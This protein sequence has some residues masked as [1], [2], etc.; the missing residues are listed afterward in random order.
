[1]NKNVLF[2]SHAATSEVMGGIEIYASY[3]RTVIPGLLH[4]DYHSLRGQLGDSILPALR[5]PVRAKKL[6]DIVNRGYP[7]VEVIITNGMFSWNLRSAMQVNLCHG[8]YAAFA[9]A[10]LNRMSLDYYRLKY[11]Y[12][13]FEKKAARNAKEVVSNSK[14]TCSNVKKYFGLASTLIYPPV[15]T[16]IF[17]PSGSSGAKSKLGW[18]GTNV[19]FVGRPEKA[20]GFDI[21]QRLAVKHPEINF[22]CVLSRPIAPSASVKPNLEAIGPKTHAELPAYYNA[23]DLILLPSRFEGFGLVAAEALACNRKVITLDTGIAREIQSENLFVAGEGKDDVMGIERIF[24]KALDA[25]DSNSRK[26]VVKF[27]SLQRFA[28]QWKQVLDGI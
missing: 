14:G 7:D 16:E 2:L 4:L 22:R 25:Q 11:I 23:A 20:K 3:L 26:I 13:Q 1:M 27:F 28:S 17:K 12:S 24:Q 8:T 10:A 21:V 18:S 19:L 6:G 5:E 9:D 15:E